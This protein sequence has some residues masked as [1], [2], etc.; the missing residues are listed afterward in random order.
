LRVGSKETLKN[1]EKLTAEVRTLLPRTEVYEKELDRLLL[2]A[3]RCRYIEIAY[4]GPKL[5]I[6]DIIKTP[7]LRDGESGIVGFAVDRTPHH[8]SVFESLQKG[9]SE[10][11]IER[12]LKSDMAKAYHISD[13]GEECKEFFHTMTTTPSFFA[14]DK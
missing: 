2:K 5:K 1:I 4:L 11:F 6:F 7:L 12:V 8:E 14:E 3:K 9:I 13:P 10:G